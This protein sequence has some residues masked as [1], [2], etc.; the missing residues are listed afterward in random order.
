MAAD[1]G[2]IIKENS[3]CEDLKLRK[4]GPCSMHHKWLQPTFF[5]GM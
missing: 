4:C 1:S 3:Y 2:E 5:C